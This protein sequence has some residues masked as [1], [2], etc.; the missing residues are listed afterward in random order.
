MTFRVAAVQFAVGDDLAE[1]ISKCLRFL[2]QAAHAGA[3]LVVFPEFCHLPSANRSGAQAHRIAVTDDHPF[4]E[5]MRSGARQHG[6]WAAINAFEQGPFPQVF[7]TTFLL[8]ST[9]A[10]VGR[11]HKHLLFG[12]ERNWL[13]PG[14]DGHP[15]FATPFGRIG[16]FTCMDGLIPEPA[17]CLAVQGAQV[18][19][20][21]LNS[22]GP[23]EPGL[24]IPVRAL[25]NGVWV[26]AA[27]KV[28]P[29][30]H[31]ATV[32][33][34]GGSMIVAPDGTVVA[35]A[36]E[37]S[38]TL[39]LAEIDA[40]QA[41]PT[42]LRGRRPAA[43]AMLYRAPAG[44]V[45]L[46][47]SA[48]T[49]SV[50]LNDWTV[51]WED[52]AVVVLNPSGERCASYRSV[53]ADG[54]ER[55]VVVPTPFGNL[56]LSAGEDL[57]YPE[58][59]RCLALQGADLIVHLGEWHDMLLVERAAENR[60]CALAI[61]P[62]RCGVVELGPLQSEPHWLHRQPHL[63]SGPELTAELDLQYARIKGDQ[64]AGRCA[65]DC[66][67]FVQAGDTTQLAHVAKGS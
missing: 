54:D 36:D 62:T 39:V 48:V 13:T 15:V 56:G 29:V 57:W 40:D 37:T 41:D 66:A 26:V 22:G 65:E 16:M 1:N 14:R 9:G 8:S 53:H 43:Y 27:N 3:Q 60:V 33:Y 10:F 49:L 5:A 35:Q 17:R 64:L 50:K 38:E 52:D 23:D 32:R 45:G 4:L 28:G 59:A 7:D 44:R 51:R 12:P 18:L 19:L 55:F 31:G 47:A 11:Y 67:A 24:H 30:A 63:E 6:V 58:A 2:E 46:Q 25:E 20:N 42:R 21:C 34:I 61:G